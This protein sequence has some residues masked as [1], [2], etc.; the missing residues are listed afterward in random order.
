MHHRLALDVQ[1]DAVCQR[2][3]RRHAQG[4]AGE[5]AFSKEIVFPENTQGCFSAVFRYHAEFHF[6]ALNK[7]QAILSIAL[8]EDGFLLCKRHHV[9][10]LPNRRKKGVGIENRDSLRGRDFL[11]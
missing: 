3:G 5:T 11:L 4:L 2:G 7:E 8:S 9:S 1:Q 6:P 10:A